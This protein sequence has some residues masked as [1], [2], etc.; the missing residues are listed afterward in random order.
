M[1]FAG[2]A[3]VQAQGTSEQLKQIRSEVSVTVNDREFYLHTI[4]RGQTLYMISKAY[5]VD[6]NDIIRENPEVKDGIRADQ[7]IRIPKP[8]S[9]QKEKAPAKEKKAEKKTEPVV[10][11]KPADTIVPPAEPVALLP[12]GADNSTK[13]SVYKVALML[14]LY[15]SEVAGLDAEN[16]DRQTL[17]TARP[18]TFLP[19]YEGFRM[20]F[21]SL[22]AAGL[23]VQL[24]VYDVG[25][26]TSKTRQLLRKPE[27]KEFDLIIGLLYHRNFQMVAEFAEKQKIPVV[28][29]ISERS[30]L[31][32]G[33][34]Y[35][36]KVQPAKEE[37][38]PEVAR[39][40]S[41]H[42]GSGQVI[43]FRGGGYA[44]AG[45][46]DKLK[47]ACAALGLDIR[48]AESQSAAI[49]LLEK[50][51]ENFLVV[52][53]T[54]N[55]YA[56]DLTRRLYELRNDY[57]M[58]LVGLPDWNAIEGLETE[59]LVTLR[60]HL[61]APA[62][63]DYSDSAVVRF[64]RAYQALYFTD[65]SPQ[66][67]QGYDIATYFLTALQQYGTGFGRCLSEM[68]HMPMQA[69]FDFMHEKGD[70]YENRHWMIYRYG[71]YRLV[72]LN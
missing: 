54:S 45:A 49:T 43:T 13:K 68:H 22:H 40:L 48:V 31:L 38:I 12:C 20:A 59:Y 33:N 26:D 5:G 72:R 70:G 42:T 50:E 10:V 11:V 63:I 7:K 25:K 6:V 4:R 37:L 32:K 69:G 53:N 65:P 21:D 61:A 51:R 8:G 34:P 27:L 24:T 3:V 16:P 58:T 62:F 19:F 35:V 56:L 67:F 30:E 14:P 28:N 41:T 36:Y 46:P 17:S 9:V 15:L 18:L 60:T 66:A 47:K 2:L 44:D 52:F 55:E 57:P 1:L 71:N 39:Y 23:P 64:V 29:P